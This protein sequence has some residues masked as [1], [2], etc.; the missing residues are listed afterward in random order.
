M[1]REPLKGKV[2]QLLQTGTEIRQLGILSG[3]RS[4]TSYL[5]I[6]L[7]VHSLTANIIYVTPVGV[8][9]SHHSS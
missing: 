5:A 3:G 1:I 2:F 4:E 9:L 7:N 6:F 8:V